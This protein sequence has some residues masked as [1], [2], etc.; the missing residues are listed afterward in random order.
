M[1]RDASALVLGHDRAR[2]LHAQASEVLAGGVS[3]NFR[4]NGTPV[5]LAFERGEG[6]WLV[7]VDGNRYA[8]YALGMGADIL[9]HAPA[10]VVAA[11]ADS[12]RCTPQTFSV[13]F[14]KQSLTA[15]A[16]TQQWSN[17]SLAVV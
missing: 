13:L 5:P 14:K 15:L 6:P 2:V 1:Q 7:D 3:S 10:G 8:D 9:G 4:L 11:V 12:P 17:K 16:L